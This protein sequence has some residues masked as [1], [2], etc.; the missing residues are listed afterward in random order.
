MS[1]YEVEWNG[2]IIRVEAESEPKAKYQAWKQFTRPYELFEGM[3]FK[4][5]LSARVSAGF[6]R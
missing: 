2:Y 4:E 6:W 3:A 5:F 1:Q